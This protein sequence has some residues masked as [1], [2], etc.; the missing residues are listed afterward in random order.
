MTDRKV[1]VMEV[2]F[3]TDTIVVT[4]QDNFR[5]RDLEALIEVTNA[6]LNMNG[7]HKDI[8]QEFNSIGKQL[9]YCRS[10]QACAI[11]QR[12]LLVRRVRFEAANY[13]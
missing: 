7:S 10:D 11:I 5:Q 12:H 4:L 8:F 3:R 13:A 2:P 6:V 9:V 1:Q